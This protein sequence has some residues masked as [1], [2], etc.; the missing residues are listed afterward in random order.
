[1]CSNM[2]TVNDESRTSEPMRAS[3]EGLSVGMV[4]GNERLAAWSVCAASFRAVC[5]GVRSLAGSLG[6]VCFSRASVL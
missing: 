2:S 4:F 1:M 6:N 3:S 5:S